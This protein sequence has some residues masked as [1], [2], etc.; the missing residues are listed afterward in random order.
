MV[1]KSSE[2][3]RTNCEELSIKGKTFTVPLTYIAGRTVIITG[4]WVKAA[5]VKDE[6][7]CEG[8]AVA[9][10]DL[11]IAKLR[12]SGTKADIFSFAQKPA[13]LGPK[14]AY[15]MELDNA[16]VIPITTSLD[17]WEKRL[18]QETRRNVRRAAKLGIIV[19]SVEFNDE[20]VRGI[21]EIY[22]ETPIRQ[23][24]T[25]WHYGKDLEAV[26]KENSTYLDR[27]EFI[28][29]YFKDELVGFAKIVYV[30]RTASIMQ[31]LSKN[32]HSDKRP[33]NALVAKA[34]EIGEKRKMSYLMYCKY[35]YGKNDK[36]ALTE[37]KRRNGF[38][39][40]LYP[41]YYVPLTLKGRVILWLR[42]HHGLSG[43][44]PK[45]LWPVLVGARTKFFRMVG[46]RK[47]AAAAIS[48][49]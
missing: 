20:F 15:H 35:I 43:L 9:D 10:P 29:A 25:F 21:V 17:W 42:L 1:F 5:F 19:R 30:E 40:V 8:I 37:F 27:S 36:S 11:F 48:L 44:V 26:R 31:I 33:S 32:A 3:M 2:A 47:P 28:G 6:D 39:Q 14:L 49:S 34:V 23:G 12:Q 22:N 18:P 46:R 24:R 45:S 7:L 38:E 41:R 16:A 4:T 13:Q